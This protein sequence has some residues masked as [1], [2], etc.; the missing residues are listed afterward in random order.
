MY[1]YMY[2][3][4]FLSLI[5]DTYFHIGLKLIYTLWMTHKILTILFAGGSS[6]LHWLTRCPIS[7][8]SIVPA[9]SIWKAPGTSFNQTPRLRFH[10]SRVWK[11]LSF[12]WSKGVPRPSVL[13]VLKVSLLF[14][15]V[16]L[17]FLPRWSLFDICII[18]TYIYMFEC[19]F[20]R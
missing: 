19:L 8:S 13:V 15:Y 3:L 11:M 16:Y 4:F 14:T 1:I 6:N 18:N 5:I 17:S 7:R 10:F 2:R 12:S 9:W 20:K